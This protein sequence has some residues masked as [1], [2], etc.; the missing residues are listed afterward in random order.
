MLSA[1]S[2]TTRFQSLG[3]RLILLGILTAGSPTFAQFPLPSKTKSTTATPTG[4][5][6][7]LNRETPQGTVQGFIRAVGKENYKRA[8]RYLDLPKQVPGKAPRTG[9]QLAQ[10]LQQLLD[11]QGS[12]IPESLISNDSIGKRSDELGLE[13]DKVGEAVVNGQTIPILLERK[14][15]PGLGM[16]WLF[17]APTMQRIPDLSALTER[18]IVNRMLPESLIINK[19]GGVP[20]GHWLVMLVLLVAAYVVAQLLVTFATWLL[21]SFWYKAREEHTSQ[22]I[23]AFGPPVRLFLTVV[24]FTAES[25]VI[26]VSIVVRQRFGEIIVTIGLVAFLLLLWRLIDVFSEYAKRRLLVSGQAGRLSAVLF[27]RRG[28]KVALVSFGAISVLNVLGWDV[29]TGIAAL[30]IGGIALALGAQKTIENFVGSITIIADQPLRV[31]DFCKVD[32]TVGTV[33]QIG[34]RSTRLRTPNRTIVVIPNGQLAA[35]KIENFA[36][37][38]RLLFNPTLGLRYETTP[39]QIRYVLVQLRSLLQ[40]HPKV[41]PNPARVRFTGLGDN[42][43]NVEIFAYIST[44]DFNEFLAVQ[45]ELVLRIMDILDETGTGIAFPSQ[46]VYVGSDS[47]QSEEKVKQ[48]EAKGREIR[49]KDEQDRAD[50][51]DT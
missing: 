35:L 3:I 37:R 5:A 2:L 45:E 31:G 4:P 48:A 1:N 49:T 10:A 43:L 12:L 23:K 50:A 41:D 44:T 38:D 15:V 19:W 40:N 47:T 16:L 13:L 21:R 27:I 28:I 22:I 14:D 9:P 36:F 8:A 39:D 42:A 11:Q 30:G 25:G 17:S 24:L 32:G 46:T 18:S 7:S 29:T 20:V 33:E 26:G 6:D 34:I 51:A